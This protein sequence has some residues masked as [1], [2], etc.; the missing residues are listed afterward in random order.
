[1]GLI[2][3]FPQKPPHIKFHTYRSRGARAYTRGQTDLTKLKGALVIHWN[4][5]KK[6]CILPT[7]FLR[8][9]HMI[10]TK[11]R[12]YAPQQMVFVTERRVS[13]LQ[14]PKFQIFKYESFYVSVLE[15]R[16]VHDNAI[17]SAVWRVSFDQMEGQWRKQ[18]QWMCMVTQ[19]MYR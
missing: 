11:S 4:A 9:C 7:H 17:C 3:K 5:P 15:I 12:D 2:Y 13:V 19:C 14:E 6:S 1:M 8:M 18:G 10:T 16:A